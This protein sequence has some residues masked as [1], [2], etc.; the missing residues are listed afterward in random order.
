MKGQPEQGRNVVCRASSSS[1]GLRSQEQQRRHQKA[2]FQVPGN[3]VSRGMI[4]SSVGDSEIIVRDGGSVSKPLT[5]S[6]VRAILLVCLAIL[7]I[8]NHISY[9]KSALV[10]QAFHDEE[11]FSS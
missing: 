5:F 1:R 3:H 7:T 11:Q 10:T 2:M 4:K 8:S 6:K 9:F